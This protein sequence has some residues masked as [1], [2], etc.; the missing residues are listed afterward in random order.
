MFVQDNVCNSYYYEFTPAYVEVKPSIEILRSEI[1]VTPEQFSIIDGNTEYSVSVKDN[2]KYSTKT[3]FYLDN[4]LVGTKV[5]TS[6]G[7]DYNYSISD[8]L[9]RTNSISYCLKRILTISDSKKCESNM[10][11]NNILANKGFTSAFLI[12]TI[13]GSNN[14]P[15]SEITIETESLP[16]YDGAPLATSSIRYQWMKRYTNSSTWATIP[17]ANTSTLNVYADALGTDYVYACKL[18][19]TPDASTSETSIYSNSIT[20]NGYKRLTASIVNAIWNEEKT[21]TI[22]I[23]KGSSI[24]NLTVSNTFSSDTIDQTSLK[25]QWY[26]KKSSESEWKKVED[27]NIIVGSTTNSLSWSDNNIQENTLLRCLVTDRC[28]NGSFSSNYILISINNNASISSNNITMLSS[29]IIDTDIDSLS[30]SIPSSDSRIKI[31]WFYNAEK[32]AFGNPITFNKTDGTLPGTTAGEQISYY[33]AGS[34][35]INVFSINNAGCSSDTIQHTY[36]LYNKLQVTGAFS[37]RTD[38]LC[39]SSS[40]AASIILNEITGGS[41]VYSIDWYYKTNSMNSFVPLNNENVN[42]YYVLSQ[43]S[44]QINK[45][46]GLEETT[47]FYAKISSPGYPGKSI[48]S[49]VATIYVYRDIESGTIDNVDELACFGTYISIN[50]K[51][52]ATGGSGVYTYNWIKSIDGGIS[53]SNIE[54]QNN[55]NYIPNSSSYNMYENTLIKRIVTDDICRISDTTNSKSFYVS[56]QVIIDSMDISAPTGI[57]SGE[58]AYIYG[59]NENYS[60]IWYEQNGFHPID[61]T[62][63]TNPFISDNLYAKTTFITKKVNQQGCKSDNFISTTIRTYE[64]LTGGVIEFNKFPKV[65]EKK[66][67][68]CSGS[69]I[70]QISNFGDSPSGINLSYEWYYCTSSEAN[71]NNILKSKSGVNI[72]TETVDMDT[73]SLVFNNIKTGKDLI[74]YIYRIT[75][76][77]DQFGNVSYAYSDTL[78]L[79]VAPTLASVNTYLIDNVAGELSCDKLTYCPNTSGNKITHNITESVYNDWMLQKFGALPFNNNLTVYWEQASG[80]GNSVGEWSRILT[81]DFTEESRYTNAYSIENVDKTYSVRL[82]I[83]DGCSSISSNIIPQKV[84]AID[85]VIDSLFIINKGVEEGDDIKIVYNNIEWDCNWYNDA[86]G[87]DTITKG[88]RYISLDNVSMSQRLYLQLEDSWTKCKSDIHKVP[89]VVYPE[90]NGGSIIQSQIICKNAEYK[91]LYNIVPASGSNGDF[92]YQWQISTNLDMWNNIDGAT[93]KDIDQ[94]KIN[95][96]ARYQTQ[97]IRRKATSSFGREVYSDTLKLDHYSNLIAGKISFADSSLTT[98]FC[99]V[100]NIPLIKTTQPTGGKSGAENYPYKIGWEY[101]INNNEYKIYSPATYSQI[102]IDPN[103]LILLSSLNREVNNTIKIRAIYE[104][105]ECEQTYSNVMEITLYRETTAPS[106]Y[107][108]KDS[109]ESEKVTVIVQDQTNYNYMWFVQ[110]SDGTTSWEQTGIFEKVLTRNNEFD[111]LEYGI[112]GS[113]VKTGCK[114]DITYFN[115]DSLPVLAQTQLKGIDT[116]CYNSDIL[117]PMEDATGGSGDKTYQW[118][119]SYDNVIFIDE[120]SATDRDLKYSNIRTNT[121]FRRI[122]NDMCSSDTSN[123]VKISVRKDFLKSDVVFSDRKCENQKFKVSMKEVSSQDSLVELGQYR[124]YVYDADSFDLEEALKI[125]SDSIENDNITK[126]GYA[127]SSSSVMISKM[128]PGFEGDSHNYVVMQMYKDPNIGCY[129]L[130]K[131]KA[132]TATKIEQGNIISCDQIKPCNN[133]VVKI[134]GDSVVMNSYNDN[135]T[136][137][138]QK[139]TDNINWDNILLESET[140]ANIEIVDTMYVKRITNNGCM[141]YESNVITFIGQ[142]RDSVDYEHI[143]GLSY[144]TIISDTTDSVISYITATQEELANYSYQG[145]GVMPS[146]E[147]GNQV[148]PYPST[149]YKDKTLYLEQTNICTYRQRIKPLSGG[150][151]V[152]DGEAIVCA[153]NEMPTIFAT[154]VEG[155][156]ST[157]H[158]QWQYKN[159]HTNEYVNIDDATTKNYTPTTV[160]VPTSY[161]RITTC[162]M[163]SIISNNIEVEI[164]TT[165]KISDII[166][167]IDTTY[168]ESHNLQFSPSGIEKALGS[169][170]RLKVHLNNAII[171]KWQS[172]KDQ[173]VWND[174][175]PMKEVSDSD[176]VSIGDTAAVSVLYVRYVASN[177]CVAKFSNVYAITMLTDP[178][179]FEED[180]DIKDNQCIGSDVYVRCYD[181]SLHTTN[182]S[183]EYRYI[184]SGYEGK[185]SDAKTGEAITDTTLNLYGVYLKD[186]TEPFS[187]KIT[188]VSIITGIS[189]SIYTD[190]KVS[191]V[192]SVFDYTINEITYSSEQ[193][194]TIQQGDLVTF[195]NKTE[196]DNSYYWELIDPINPQYSSS[197]Y[198]L[199]STLAS[200]KS[201]FYNGG[202]HKVKLISTNKDG[203]SDTLIVNAIYVDESTLRSSEVRQSFFFEDD[204]I[205]LLTPENKVMVYPNPV[206]DFLNIS[207]EKEVKCII[208]TILGEYIYEAFGTNICIDMRNYPA[209]IYMVTIED[210]TYKIVK[211]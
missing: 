197:P 144:T 99:S 112:I 119:S 163:Y 143:L 182:T 13:N 188:R 166:A 125:H 208:Q 55:S 81:N 12:K 21:S 179:I 14:C 58:K 140:S 113:D 170:I 96:S 126:I 35:T 122:A 71:C 32:T 37:T 89:L 26:T 199:Y 149:T 131:N 162:G 147:H 59:T 92:E 206:S 157:Y 145:D 107:Q 183:S 78:S 93:D 189:S 25:F 1:E 194:A 24:E 106:I 151:L 123:A 54:G 27:S 129:S 193:E 117:L 49:T 196:G 204:A 39:P 133:S 155:G 17:N 79:H 158:Y 43:D 51:N 134:A 68:I 103:L 64:K 52:Q 200:P 121:Y 63:G 180:L 56:D 91:E 118:Q 135:F 207:S 60:Y 154:E 61:T 108:R 38:T 3:E 181:N 130:N 50:N 205:A 4:K 136:F 29:K 101:A 187:L 76:S 191:S 124:W 110:E 148:L 161:R 9:A 109:C 156:D 105:K 97:Y 168:Y 198:G 175:E 69:S 111:V 15:N 100:N 47:S 77:T 84:I 44:M 142:K 159:I 2:C 102:T 74:Y 192:K 211:K 139:S 57:T 185:M 104:D 48:T 86:T 88:I 87:T 18:T 11:C 41:G 66:A 7:T 174:I 186:V 201:F 95:E 210:R 164:R 70:G 132:Y 82:T 115:L 114:T 75:Y 178:I 65:D 184:Y 53:W 150:K 67:W 116:V 83:N 176:Y 171:G 127:S 34:H 94:T 85:D 20:I 62:K 5:R 72:N 169:K 40:S 36:T 120:E 177:Y 146:L 152:L 19:Y 90:S 28:G 23:C 33:E 45:I 10:Y 22:S 128:M 167:D 16:Y 46:K 153:G 209:N 6:S 8:S 160:D 98:A 73:C 42:F 31:G 137:Y 202:H 141:D 195:N 80:S 190:I 173:S 138:W 203:C 172:S 165:P 30:F